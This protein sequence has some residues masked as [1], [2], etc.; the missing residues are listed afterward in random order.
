M[1]LGKCGAV[2][3]AHQRL[4]FVLDQH[5]LAFQHDDEL[6][7]ALVPVAL[8]GDP[9]GLE[10][11]VADAEIGQAG[12]GREAAIVALR[13]LLAPGR[14]IAGAIDLFDAVEIELGHGPL[15]PALLGA[16]PGHSASTRS[17]SP[18]A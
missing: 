6:V 9:A 1:P 7:L 8:R 17:T 15:L 5:R 2:A 18:P 3:G 10:R 14:G 11:D 13:H 4:A 16:R 12:G